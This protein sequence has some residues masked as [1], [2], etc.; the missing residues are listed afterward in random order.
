MYIIVYLVLGLL[1]YVLTWIVGRLMPKDT[2]TQDLI[3]GYRR[4]MQ[5][6]DDTAIEEME[7]E[8]RKVCGT[9]PIWL[10]YTIIWPIATTVLIISLTGYFKNK[11][12]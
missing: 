7:V 3:D 11:K 8:V 10:A 2:G 4:E 9:I 6:D 12:D 1:S 5:F